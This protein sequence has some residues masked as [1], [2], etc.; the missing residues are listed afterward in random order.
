MDKRKRRE[1]G[2]EEE[3]EGGELYNIERQRTL[4]KHLCPYIIHTHLQQQVSVDVMGS[5][6]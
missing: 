6:A 5:S 1:T 4:S 2:E 3:G